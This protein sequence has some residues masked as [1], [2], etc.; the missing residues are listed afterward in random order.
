MFTLITSPAS[1]LLVRS[2]LLPSSLLPPTPDLCT[3]VSNLSASLT[4]AWPA[5]RTAVSRAGKEASPV[6][7]SV[8]RPGTWK[9]LQAWLRRK[10]CQRKGCL[11]SAPVKG[12]VAQ[13]LR[14]AVLGSRKVVVA[15][16]E[17]R[18]RF[19]SPVA[20][21]KVRFSEDAAEPVLDPAS[22]LLT[23]LP[24]TPIP[25]PRPFNQS[26]L[27]APKKVKKSLLGRGPWLKSCLRSSQLPAKPKRSIRFAAIQLVQE[28]TP[29]NSD[30]RDGPWV[31]QVLPAPYE[32]GQKRVMWASGK[33]I[34][35]YSV[36]TYLE[37]EGHLQ[38][39]FPLTKWIFNVP[40]IDDVDA[41]GD[42]DMC[43]G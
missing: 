30:E 34:T 18:I 16:S 9:Q 7:G 1:S 4:G 11:I 6:P 27:A 14:S 32:R 37:P 22:Q 28:Y 38:L 2:L 39:N 3:A 43:D 31:P 36:S 25:R 15:E 29:W 21:R 24:G 13:R 5:R 35:E 23:T 8:R 41:D 20:N 26:L 17:N 40:A 19:L 12:G 33:G 42:V 10:T